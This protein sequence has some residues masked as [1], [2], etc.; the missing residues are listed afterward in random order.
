MDS[1]EVRQLDALA[2][3]LVAVDARLTARVAYD[4]RT[5]ML[6]CDVAF[7]PRD[8]DSSVAV[9]NFGLAIR[10]EGKQPAELELFV[11]D[12]IRQLI[13]RAHV[14]PAL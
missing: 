5:D 14:R 10:A 1:S 13:S 12:V 2:K 11:W 8:P 4:Q 9:S 7:D 3:V 6:S